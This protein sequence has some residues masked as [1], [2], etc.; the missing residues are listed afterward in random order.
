[1]LVLC[2]K[3]GEKVQIGDHIEITVVRISQ[4]SVRLGVDAPR[5]FQIVRNEIKGQPL[6]ADLDRATEEDE[7]STAGPR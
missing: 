6:S 1:M 7:P 3:V 5:D 2:R 4:N